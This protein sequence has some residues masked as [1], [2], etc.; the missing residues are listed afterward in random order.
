MA[1]TI[2]NLVLDAALQYEKAG[3]SVIYVE[4]K[5]KYPVGQSWTQYQ[6]TAATPDE[7][8]AWFQ[9]TLRGLCL[10]T[11]KVSG[12]IGPDG[13]VY[14]LEMLDFDEPGLY[15][16]FCEQAHKLGLS[17][18]I[19][20]LPLETTPC[21]GAHTGWFCAT[22]EGSLTLAKQ[23]A[24]AEELAENPTK[25]MKIRIETRGEGGMCVVAPTPPRIHPKTPERGYD[26]VRGSWASIPT[27]TPEE[28][29]WLFNIA[30]SYRTATIEEGP[31][32]KLDPGE[33]DT[34]TPGGDYNAQATPEK[35]KALL[36]KHDWTLLYLRRDGVQIWQRPG[37]K[38]REGGSATLG[39]T[40]AG[41]YVFSTNADPIAGRRYYS[42]FSAYTKLEHGDDVKAAARALG[43]EGYGT[44]APKKNIRATAS[45]GQNGTQATA[46]PEG[47]APVI[48]SLADVE[49]LPLDW[50]WP[51]YMAYGHIILVDGDPGIGKSLFTLF[52]ASRVTKGDP[53]LDQ[54]G[55]R[56][57]IRTEPGNVLLLSA[58]DS[59]AYTIKKRIRQSEGDASRIFALTGWLD[60]DKKEQFFEL[61]HIDILEQAMAQ[62]TP[63]FVV[64]DPVAAYMGKTDMHRGNE[65]MELLRPI[66]KLA[67]K[68]HAVIAL[69]RHPAKPGK[70]NAA[71]AIYRGQGN[72][73]IAGIARSAVFVEQHPHDANKAFFCHYKSNHGPL[74]RT[75]V[76]SK[77]E[78]QFRWCGVTRLT[79]EMIAGG[80]RGQF[81][82]CLVWLED[83]MAGGIPT[84]LKDLEDAAEEAGFAKSM[85]R[86]TRKALGVIANKDHA[87]DGGW[88]WRLPP[89]AII[90]TR[91]GDTS[92][93]S[94]SSTSS[95]SS[96][97]LTT[98]IG[99]TERIEVDS[100]DEVVEQFEV[101]E[102]ETPVVGDITKCFQCG[103]TV[104]V[105]SGFWKCDGCPAA[106]AV[107]GDKPLAEA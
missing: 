78:G 30:R 47:A 62:H 8:R 65:V 68:Y 2:T 99:Y 22:I 87:E 60:A 45:V 61:K 74:G 80:G 70:D 52:L 28:R 40:G 66:G 64:I 71:K 49:E 6:T 48:M 77:E 105:I 38:R 32:K 97:S 51:P 55:H 88:Y 63:R 10:V 31:T 84:P 44:P 41:L 76:F 59:L 79:A 92:T 12:W 43:K 50:L 18:L 81:L 102:L 85:L 17:E 33:N 104:K 53:L 1:T 46:K 37:K 103:G 54:Q 93:S 4:P 27:I 67:E 5:T 82:E 21:G 98:T 75:Q 86:R 16:E 29:D 20:R 56:T 3:R 14:S 72:I 11:G 36:E 35:W 94:I 95:T 19:E 39:K 9:D 13:T 107:D 26:M 96:T 90:P 25:K 42:L 83:R 7:L 23:D 58:E 24:T 91:E 15:E 69:V 57:T 100:Q 73:S 34:S 89:L 101:V 106:W